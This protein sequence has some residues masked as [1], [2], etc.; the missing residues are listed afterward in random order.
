MVEAGQAAGLVK[1]F[2]VLRLQLHT[3]LE[4]IGEWPKV[5]SLGKKDE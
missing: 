2:S 5:F 1:I 3:P 4:G